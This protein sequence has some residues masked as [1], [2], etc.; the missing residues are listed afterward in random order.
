DPPPSVARLSARAG[1]APEHRFSFAPPALAPAFA[2]GPFHADDIRC[3]F[4]SP[5]PGKLACCARTCRRRRATDA[6]RKIRKLRTNRSSRRTGRSPRIL[7]S[8]VAGKRQ[9]GLGRRA[10]S[11]SVRNG[12]AH[13]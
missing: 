10:V 13:A 7:L 1:E 9:G 12:V 4:Q 3:R 11:R 5:K 8:V 6:R 2:R